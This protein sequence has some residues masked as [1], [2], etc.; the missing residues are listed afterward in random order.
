MFVEVEFVRVAFDARRFVKVD[1]RAVKI[2]V[3]RLEVVA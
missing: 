2:F 3:K 1:V